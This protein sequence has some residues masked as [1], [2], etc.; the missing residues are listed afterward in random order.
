MADEMTVMSALT[1][2]TL[3]GKHAD[4]VKSRTSPSSPFSV[5]ATVNFVSS[6]VVVKRCGRGDIFGATGKCKRQILNGMCNTCNLGV[7]DGAAY[8]DYYF[9]VGLQDWEKPSEF[10]HVNV[11]SKGGRA[12]FGMEAADYVGLDA[13][14]RQR[15]HNR[16]LFMPFV[17]V[18]AM[19]FKDD[20]VPRFAWE[21]AKV[22]G[23]SAAFKATQ[24]NW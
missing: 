21:F 13:A 17:V 3:I 15:A 5:R 11:A 16:V 20:D 18:V 9:E 6:S 1:V 10:F 24:A 14:G 19:Q 7:D 8:Y 23:S 2:E 4:I 22:S 12:L